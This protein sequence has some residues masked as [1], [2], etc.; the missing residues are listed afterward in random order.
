MTN[1]RKHLACCVVAVTIVGESLHAGVDVVNGPDL[2]GTNR[3]YVSNRAPLE[4]SRFIGLPVGSVEPRGWLQEF[5]RR[6]RDGLCGH[7]NEIDIGL[8]KKDNAWLKK[9]GKGRHGFQDVSYWLRGYIELAYLFKDPKMIAESQTWINGV[10]NNQRPNGD[11]GPDYTFADDGSRD[12]WVNMVMM[13]CLE[14]YYE[15]SQDPR[16]IDLMTKYFQY[17]LS[18]PDD[19]LL[20]HY[21][22][23]M[24]GGDEL[25][26]IY[27]LYNRTGDPG[28]LKVAEKIHRCTANW[29]I[30]NDLPNWHN[31]SIAQCF[32]EPAEHYLQTHNPAELQATYANFF[33][34]RKRYGQVPG[35]MFG[36]DENCR[37][38]YSDPHQAVETCG[39]VEQML[40]DELLLQMTG[41]LFW[42]DHCE[43]VAFNTFPAAMTPD[44]RA[45][46][47]LTAPNL[48][49]S[50][51][52]DHAPGFDNNGTFLRMNSMPPSSYR[53]CLHNHSQGWPYFNKNLWLA[54]P[55]NGLL[56][57]LYS[58]SEV[59][60]KVGDGTLIR[61]AEETHYPF[62]DTIS[63][64]FSADK[65]V[66]FP[67]YLR[68]PAWCQTPT[69][70]N[71]RHEGQI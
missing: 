61:F 5:L 15:H 14:T 58:A 37:P 40:S 69:G 30:T 54:T 28:L 53:C 70:F 8:S 44:L 13:H 3:F 9:S 2:S 65:V 47:Y 34:V 43:T 33:E 10:L 16:V 4:P 23:K 46:R 29:E 62:A 56:A 57:A 71:Q 68:L 21:W 26:S 39:V 49:V 19:Q 25:Y 41:D 51:S 22:Q 12:F 7:L 55:D 64:K 38:G 27:W 36:G 6:Q 63:F 59:K 52:K 60:A 20:T 32:R 67:L 11:F 42:A 18:L 48:V 17:H 50:D 1:I 66:A 45:L 35:G 31:V 24:R